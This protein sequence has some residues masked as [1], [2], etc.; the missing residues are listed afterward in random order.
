[1]PR[2]PKMRSAKNSSSDWPETIS[3]ILPTT[4][5]DTE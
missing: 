1:M 4:S 5:V 2:G 3:M